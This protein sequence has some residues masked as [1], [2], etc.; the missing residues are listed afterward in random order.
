MKFELREVHF[1]DVMLRNPTEIEFAY[2]TEMRMKLS[3]ERSLKPVN[4]LACDE[5]GTP[6]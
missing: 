2:R 3:N 6:A 1:R 5:R 4:V